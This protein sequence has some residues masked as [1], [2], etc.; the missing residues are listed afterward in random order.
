MGSSKDQKRKA[1]RAAQRK[2]D[3]SVAEQK[4]DG[5]IPASVA[6]Q[7]SL[8]DTM[9]SMDGSEY[10]LIFL[11]YNNKECELH[12]LDKD[13]AK[14]L[15][16]KF[17]TITSLNSMTIKRSSLIRDKIEP[18]GAYKSLYVGLEQDVE[19]REIKFHDTGRIIVYLIDNHMYGEHAS[20]YCCVVAV[21]KQ[22]RKN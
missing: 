17:A 3:Q 2:I 14:A 15:I 22:H 9:A 11:N 7:P 18:T 20:S 4:T 19:L 6:I 12:K 5:L 16:K 8:P 10:Q 1:D 21:L 13:D